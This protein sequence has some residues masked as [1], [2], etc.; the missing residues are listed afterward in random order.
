MNRDYHIRSASR[1]D[2]PALSKFIESGPRT[3]RHLDW[4]P[5]LDWLGSQPFIILDSNEGIQACLICPEDPPEIAWI[6]YFACSAS[7][8][9]LSVW[10]QL[11]DTCLAYYQKRN[12]PWLPALGLSDWFTNLL[13]RNGFTLHQHIVTLERETAAPL[14][15]IK[16]NPAVFIHLM[17]PEDLDRV[18]EIDQLAFE[19]IWQNSLSQIKLSYDMAVYATVAEIN[20][21]IV[22]FQISTSTMFSY[23]LARLAVLPKMQQKRVGLALVTDLIDRAR[24]DRIWQCTINTQDDNHSSLTLY[25]KAGFTLTGDKF[26]VFLYKMQANL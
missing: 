24:N 20:D 18:A 6:R 5:P 22:G 21:Q 26:P 19:P 3:H 23:H 12:L 1:H 2:L 14:K 9:P 7:I 15:E 8:N 13:R 4:C 16:P 10:P 25:R 17:Q 11:F